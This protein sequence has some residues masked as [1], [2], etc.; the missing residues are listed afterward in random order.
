MVTGVTE[1][2]FTAALAAYALA[3]ADG[4]KLEAAME[5]ELA[6]VREKYA[7]RIKEH[8][9]VMVKELEQIEV[10]CT[11]NK[12]VLFSKKR[13]METVHGVVGFRLGTP[14]LKTLPK[15][16][17]AKVLDKLK[18]VLPDYVRTKEEVDK[19]R[20]LGDRTDDLVAPHLAEVGVYVDQ[21]ERFFIELKKEEAPAV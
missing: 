18:A 4:R 10:Y 1:E 12:D 2:R 7:P 6:K 13:S 9:D 11:E 8:A 17:W 5:K 15:F 14:T 19:E 16:T 21:D 20:L 3:S